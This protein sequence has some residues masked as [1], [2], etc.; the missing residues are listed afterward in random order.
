MKS[1]AQKLLKVQ[2]EVKAIAKDAVNSHFKNRYFDINT[3]IA[4]V[5]PIWNKHG[6][7]VIQPLCVIDGRN[8]L[9]T[10]IIE[11]ETG[12]QLS[13]TVLL[14]ENPDPQKI[15]AII[16]YFRRYSLTSLLCLEA[17]DEDGND[18]KPVYKEPVINRDEPPFPDSPEVAAE[19]CADC[20][21]GVYK[22][23]K[24]VKGPFY[25]CSAY[26]ACKST[27]PA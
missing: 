4:E 12:E 21:K 23:R 2:Q 18:T 22:L 25:G 20:G 14:P 6:L 17:E 5:K 26:P 19:T 11:A 13:W 8:A 7:V 15:G 3:L 10:N 1:I 9:A 16:T 27:K 24:G